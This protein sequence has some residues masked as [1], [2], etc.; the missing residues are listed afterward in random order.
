M[1]R[2][3]RPSAW[4]ASSAPRQIITEPKST[5]C[6]TPRLSIHR[7]IAMPP[8]PA[9]IISS[10]YASDGTARTVSRSAAIGLRATNRMVGA[11]RLMLCRA[12]EANTTTQP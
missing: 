11:P 8:I 4:L 9:P 6:M 1:N 3:H 5:G 7:P 12:S 2:P 10:E